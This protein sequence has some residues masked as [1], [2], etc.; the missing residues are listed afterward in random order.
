MNYRGRVG[1]SKITG[2]LKGTLRTGFR[3]I[4]IVLRY[5][6]NVS[7]RAANVV[8]RRARGVRRRAS[9]RTCRPST[10]TSFATTSGSSSCS[11][12]AGRVLSDAGS[13]RRG[14]RTSGDTLPD[15]VRPFPAVS[16]QLTALGGAASPVA[17]H[18]LNI[19]LHA[20]N[21]LLVF[22]IALLVPRLRLWCAAAGRRR[23]RAAAVAGRERR[24]DHRAAWI[25]CRR[26]STS[27]SFLCYAL[28]A[29]GARGIALRGVAASLLR[30]AVQQ[31][32][33]DHDGRRRWR[34]YDVL[35]SGARAQRSDL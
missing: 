1:E 17:H 25:R 2:T 11:P 3:M 29:S 26:S 5:R 9:C 14:W 8:A 33:D 19:A 16:Y 22:A 12:E 6:F 31:A 20:A 23:L 24:V 15:E 4:G 10:T 30:R 7:D 28:G 13:T 34:L 35:A 32:D 18:V 27:S 21:G